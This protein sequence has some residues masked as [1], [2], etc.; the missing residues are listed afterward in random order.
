MKRGSYIGRTLEVRESFSFAAPAQVLAA[1]DLYVGMLWRLDDQPAQ[2]VMNCWFTSV[3]DVWGVSRATHTTTA[4]WLACGNTG[5]KE[6]LLA[7]WVKY[8]QSML[9]SKSL[10]VT[11]I[12]RVAASD[13]RTTTGANNAMILDLGLDP[14][15]VTP[16]MVRQTLREQKPVETLEQMARLGLLLELLEQRGEGYY[17]GEEEDQDANIMI[18]FLCTN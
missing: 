17:H 6:D 13:R 10:E 3:K 14:F 9:K 18:D 1:S 5:F 16:R 4:R 8:F 2:Q 15:T 11:T 7:R 12:A